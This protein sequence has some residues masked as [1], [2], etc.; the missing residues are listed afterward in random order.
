M[1]PI[2][3]LIN[4][5]P[6]KTRITAIYDSTYHV[7]ISSITEDLNN[8]MV[9]LPYNIKEQSYIDGN[10]A[11]TVSFDKNSLSS[12]TFNELHYNPASLVYRDRVF[13]TRPSIKISVVDSSQI[14]RT[15]KDGTSTVPLNTDIHLIVKYYDP[16]NVG[17]DKIFSEVKMM[18]KTGFLN[19]PSLFEL[20]AQTKSFEFVVKS[21]FPGMVILRAK[22]TKYL[23]SYTPLQLKFVP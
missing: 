12:D 20:D 13:L 21:S 6:V 22:D 11:K 19:V 15:L 2:E 8:L 3:E 10:P 7:V 14:I 23:C 5:T 16:D 1:F 4:I 18:D 17:F 9:M